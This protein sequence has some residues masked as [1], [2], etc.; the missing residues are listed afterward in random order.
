LGA[1]Q[2]KVGKGSSVLGIRRQNA[3]PRVTSLCGTHNKIKP[4]TKRLKETTK[5]KANRTAVHSKVKAI[6]F[7]N[8]TKKGKLRYAEL[9]S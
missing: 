3:E 7:E 9:F 2:K 8:Y 6:S 4:I 5:C 1:N